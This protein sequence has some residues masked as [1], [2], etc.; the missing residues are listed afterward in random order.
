MSSV[1]YDFVFNGAGKKPQLNEIQHVLE[2]EVFFV[3]LIKKR[4]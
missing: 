4:K 2:S 3:E 1:D